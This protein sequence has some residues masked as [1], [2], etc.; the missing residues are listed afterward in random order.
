MKHLLCLLLTLACCLPTGAQP[1]RYSANFSFS[2]NNFCDTIPIMIEDDQIYINID[3]NGR[4]FRFNLDTGSSQGTVVGTEGLGSW[5]ELG[6]VVSR[7]ANGRMDT[8]K[9]IQMPPFRI[10]N[11]VVNDYI[12]TI[13]PHPPIKGRY[14]G[15]IGFDFIHKGLCTKIDAEHHR[16]II[17]DRRSAFDGEPG[18][19][20]RYKLKWFVPY[21][22]VSPFI[23]HVDESLLDLGSRQLYTMNK[24][25]FDRHAYKSK[26]VNAQVEGFA[27]G[28]LAIGSYGTEQHDEVAFL[29]LDRLKWGDL[30][31]NDVRAVTTQGTSRIGARILRYGNLIIDPF[32]RQIIFQPHNDS[33]SV[34]VANRQFGVA[35]IPREGKPVVGLIFPKCEAYLNGMRQGDT[36]IRIDNQPINDFRQFVNFPFAEGR[37]YT[38]FLI[39]A[40]GQEKQVSVGR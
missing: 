30:S 19:A 20:L 9:V 10:G 24:E 28:S 11:L 14:A 23:R 16:L 33:S 38:F 15:T 37:R 8:V 4:L 1:Y 18:Y 12:A 7:D 5:R 22:L 35:F 34:T 25:S 39:S 17:S 27:K 3:V 40:D 26:Q 2:K 36:I 31:F 32:R 21:L 13:Q 6:N 29:H